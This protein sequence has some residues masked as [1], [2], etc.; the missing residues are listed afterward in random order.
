MVDGM[1]MLHTTLVVVDDVF[2]LISQAVSLT[3]LLNFTLPP[4]FRADTLLINGSLTPN[5]G[6]T[7]AINRLNP[8][9]TTV[10]IFDGVDDALRACV[11]SM[12]RIATVG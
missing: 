2:D 5:V 7:Y 4:N 6:S 11:S 10:V 1:D 12:A 8:V 3:N 9:L